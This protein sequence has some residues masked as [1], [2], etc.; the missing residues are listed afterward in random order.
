MKLCLANVKEVVFISTKVGERTEDNRKIPVYYMGVDAEGD[1]GSLPCTVD[2][3]NYLNQVSK[4][5]PVTIV[6]N[7]DTWKRDFIVNNVALAKKKD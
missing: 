3:F 5:T 1:V 4:Y 2:V 6:C 7:F